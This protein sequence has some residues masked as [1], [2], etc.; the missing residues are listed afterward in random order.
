MEVSVIKDRLLRI[1]A[2]IHY[3]LDE[4]SKMHPKPYGGIE[5]FEKIKIDVSKR[6]SKPVDPTE[7]IREM[8]D[9]KYD[10]NI[11]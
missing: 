5:E 6:V 1:D 2:E 11:G 8:R 7:L 9:R 10:I 3:L 4:L